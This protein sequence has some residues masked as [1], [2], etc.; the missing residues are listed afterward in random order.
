M[1]TVN[2]IAKLSHP[3]LV[4]MIINA[5][6]N[7]DLTSLEVAR[8]LCREDPFPRV[9]CDKVST[10]KIE[11]ASS[12]AEIK[13]ALLNSGINFKDNGINRTLNLN[14]L[15]NAN[16]LTEIT[17]GM[18]PLSNLGIRSEASLEDVLDKSSG[19][20]AENNGKKY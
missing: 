13:S 11:H 7:Y 15:N 8:F 1:L 19:F 18:I 4:N 16:R 2:E 3:E 20:I 10:I 14:D 5:M 6:N 17:F 12:I 9:S